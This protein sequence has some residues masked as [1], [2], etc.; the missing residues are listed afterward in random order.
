M[1]EV[2]KFVGDNLARVGAFSKDR[3]TFI[4]KRRQKTHEGVQIYPLD[5]WVFETY[6]P[7]CGKRNPDIAI[8]D[9]D[10]GETVLFP[11]LEIIQKAIRGFSDKHGSEWGIRLA[12]LGIEIE[13][14][15]DDDGDFNFI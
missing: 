5:K 15:T 4:F 3:N 14:D 2:E 7:C 8:F 10:R 13:K 1:I 6:L 12:D 11:A 9:P